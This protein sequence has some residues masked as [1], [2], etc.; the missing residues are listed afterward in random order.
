MEFRTIGIQVNGNTLDTCYTV[1]LTNNDTIW[2]NTQMVLYDHLY[3]VLTDM[4]QPH[5]VNQLDSFR[6]CGYLQGM[7]VV[8]EIFKIK[9]DECHIDYVSGKT[10]VTL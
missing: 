6:F 3:P 1:R 4:Y 7:K 8:D 9:A 2:P 5:L 10:E